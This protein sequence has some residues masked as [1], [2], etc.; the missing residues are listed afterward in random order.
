MIVGM[1]GCVCKSQQIPIQIKLQSINMALKY[2]EI[3]TDSI[4]HTWYYPSNL[5]FSFIITSALQDTT[6]MIFDEFSRNDTDK[7]FSKLRM[8]FHDKTYDLYARDVGMMMPGEVGAVYAW[9]ISLPIFDSVYT[10]KQMS[11]FIHDLLYE[12]SYY[13]VFDWD[14]YRTAAF[15][16]TNLSLDEVLVKEGV[17]LPDTLL[18]AVDPEDVWTTYECYPDK[19]PLEYI[20]YPY[21]EVPFDIKPPVPMDGIV[22]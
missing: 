14:D 13:V 19:I 16:R 12:T 21:D 10:A 4:S 15:K 18:I 22:Y 3:K 2:D 8:K 9:N 5:Y 11:H 17:N 7:E 6:E 20:G 1:F